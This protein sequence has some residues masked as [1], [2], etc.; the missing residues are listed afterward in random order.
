MNISQ[1]RLS[2]LLV[3]LLGFMPLMSASAQEAPATPVH[4]SAP[5]GVLAEFD[6]REL[7]SPHAEVWFLRAQLE[8]NG[9]V[10]MGTQS[11]QTVLYVESGELTVEAEGVVIDADRQ[12]VDA[13]AAAPIALDTN[14]S[15]MIA[16]GTEARVLNASN[17]R[18]TFLMLVM[19]SAMDEGDGGE[20]MDQPVGLTQVG[21]SV[22]TAEFNPGPATLVM[23]RVVVEPGASLQNV[24]FSGQD[25]MGPGWMGMDLGTLETGSADLLIEQQ[26][27]Q[28]LIWPPMSPDQFSPPERVVL[29]ASVSM[30]QGESYACYNSILTFTNM[31]DG[32]LTILRVIVTPH[33]GQ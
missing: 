15:L 11:G 25:E 31:G 14:G 22:G 19:Y 33:M 27:L 5:V 32:P 7:A 9:S 20:G 16:S 13:K 12:V 24:T 4:G 17:A 10:P 18:T 30:E 21:V 3:L 8:P 26:S 28:N 2:F 1:C 23:E 6:I 29:G